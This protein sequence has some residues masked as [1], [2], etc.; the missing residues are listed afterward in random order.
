M[1]HVCNVSGQ[2]NVFL[3]CTAYSGCKY[4]LEM[5]RHLSMEAVNFSKALTDSIGV[6]HAPHFLI[7]MGYAGLYNP[8]YK[9]FVSNA[10]HIYCGDSPIHVNRTV[11]AACWETRVCR[12]L[13]AALHCWG[14]KKSHPWHTQYMK[15]NRHIADTESSQA[16]TCKGD[17]SAL[18]PKKSF[19]ELNCTELSVSISVMWESI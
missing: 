1:H 3:S 15:C 10:F 7:L 12:H 6:F 16:L 18:I 2:Q 19:K 14:S 13:P 9:L 5:G 8:L 11:Q 17:L 4:S